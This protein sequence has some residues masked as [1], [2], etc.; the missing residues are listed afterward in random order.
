[1]YTDLVPKTQIACS[2]IL[3]LDQ[4]AWPHGNEKMTGKKNM[5][6]PDFPS[7]FPPFL[8][9]RVQPNLRGST[10]NPQPPMRSRSC[11]FSRS[12]A[13][14]L[15]H[16]CSLPRLAGFMVDTNG[17]LRGSLGKMSAVD[18]MIYSITSDGRIFV[19]L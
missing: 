13:R 18:L 14:S 17:I 2:P 1:M 3:S 12:N 11:R 8:D 6:F 4:H 5:F 16:F 9:R 10:T 15:R 19:V 7:D